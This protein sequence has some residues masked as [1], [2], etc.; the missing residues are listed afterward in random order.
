M[1]VDISYLHHCHVVS[2]HVQAHCHP[3]HL[4]RI[5]VQGK[6]VDAL[7]DSGSIVFLIV[8]S[9]L[10]QLQRTAAP[11]MDITC[12]HADTK[13]CP[14]VDVEIN[15]TSGWFRGNLELIENL[16]YP[17]QLGGDCPYF[18]ELCKGLQDK[19]DGCASNRA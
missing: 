1:Q 15:S 17:M 19:G 10:T 14:T 3:P 6:E 5:Q 18:Q 12:V 11:T 4:S 8:P 13:T 2:A 7:P 16:P 9:L